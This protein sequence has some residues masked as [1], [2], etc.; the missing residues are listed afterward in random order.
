[1]RYAVSAAAAALMLAVVLTAGSAVTLWVLAAMVVAANASG[2]WSLIVGLVLGAALALWAQAALVRRR[3]DPGGVSLTPDEQ[4][5]IW[6]EIY[7]VAERLGVR[8]PAQLLLFPGVTVAVSQARIWLGLRQGVRRVHLGVPVLGALSE[9]ELRALLAHEFARA[10]GT[11]SLARIIYRGQG[12]IG[13]VAA[14]VTDDSRV[15]RSA[16]WYGRAYLGVATPVTARFEQRANRASA[17]IAGKAAA[18]AALCELGVLACGWE[19]F[20]DGY[21]SPAAAVGCRCG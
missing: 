5:L 20:V 9:R 19:E 16:R 7:S 3:K 18:V 2:A 10:W 8:P 6:A 11:F 21:V 17:Q 1:M 4:P 15:G 13:W 12:I 14:R